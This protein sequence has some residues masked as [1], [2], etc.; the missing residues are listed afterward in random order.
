MKQELLKRLYD[1]EDGFV[2]RKPENCNER[3]LR[4]ELV[5][6]ANSVPEGLYGVIFLG[7]SDDGKPIGIKNPDE[8]QKK[9][10]S[11]AE[12]VCYPPIKIQMHV[13]EE[14]N[15]KFIA[16]V[17]EHSSSK[18][19]FSGPAFV[20]VGSE[21]VNATDDL[22]ENLINSRNDKCREILKYE[23]SLLTVIVQGKKLGDTKIIPGNYRAKHECRV[24]SCNQ[25]IIRLTDIA[26][27]TR[28]SEPLEN[29]NVSY[30]E[31]KYRVM[32]VV[33]QV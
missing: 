27:G 22:Y 3:E 2:E 5:A 24:N 12:K 32:L 21:C 19:H 29:V 31:E 28:L 23:G 11:V 26:T 16:V 10:R 9:I 33:R 4:K 15:L 30:D 1:D 7:V 25:H 13:L 17:V 8:K 6:F 20:R 18:P 14:D